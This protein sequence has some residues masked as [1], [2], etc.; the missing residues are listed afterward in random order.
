MEWFNDFLEKLTGFEF[1]QIITI[2]AISVGASILYKL[3]KGT[4]K[5]ILLICLALMVLSALI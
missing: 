5:F 1:H 3:F 4:F 2:A